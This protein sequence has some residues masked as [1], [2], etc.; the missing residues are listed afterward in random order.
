MCG[1]AALISYVPK[2]Q[3]EDLLKMCEAIVHRGPDGEGYVLFSEQ[4]E[5]KLVH[6]KGDLLKLE[7]ERSRVALGH[8]RLAITDISSAGSQPM[9]FGER[10]NYWVTYNGELY[11]FS[12][13]RAELSSKGYVFRSNS[14]TEILICAYA[15][16]G[17]ECLSRF[18][19]MF[20]FV[21][22][23][24]DEN[25]IFAARD[26]YGVKPL[27][28]WRPDAQTLAFASEIKQFTCLPEWVAYLNNERA[29]DYLSWGL[30]DHTIHTLF[31]GVW[32]VPPGHYVQCQINDIMSDVTATQWYSL[33]EVNQDY[34]YSESVEH[35]REILFD[36]VNLRL[37]ADVPVGAAL[38]GGLDSSSVVC[39]ADAIHRTSSSKEMHT[40]SARA[41]DKRFD[42]GRFIDLVSNKTS[43]KP[44]MVYPNHGQLFEEL[45]QIIWH[46]DEPFGSTSVYAEWQVFKRAQEAGI[47]VV[48]DGHGADETLSGYT[49]DVGFFLAS[50]LSRFR[51]IKFF[52][53]FSAQRAI[54]DRSTATLV[55]GILDNLLPTRLR[56][57]ARRV[58]G[59]SV[60][61]PDWI[62]M[63]LLGVGPSDPFVF[64]VGKYENSLKGLSRAQLTATSLPMQLKWVDRDSM[65]HSVESRAPFMDFRLVDFLLSMPDHFKLNKGVS[66]RLLRSSMKNILPDEV[67]H[68]K[69]KMGFVT[70]EEIW[71]CEDQPTHFKELLEEAVANSKGVLNKK[72]IEWGYAMIDGHA[73]YNARLWRVICFGLW[74]KRFKVQ[75]SNDYNC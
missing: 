1:I 58:M 16:W 39:I 51:I 41:K 75:I 6:K 48:L 27:Y 72:T 32:Q 36:S 65:A 11:N 20:S 15:E 4:G 73:P 2:M 23:D 47:K 29:F 3:N 42:E 60:S 13:L 10:L 30:T 61:C 74:M 53:E 44:H 14:D 18:N 62:N 25:S 22:Y 24:L 34:S 64:H 57:L 7:N 8:R 28:W 59:H 49:S 37:N 21:I 68:R 38:S 50:L 56:V 9:A 54:H 17:V 33:S 52:K 12:E 40:F 19:G 5:A 63:E 66:K 43:T 26:R 69:D 31:D 70:P 71:V 67:R 45:E 35:F 55:K 46:H